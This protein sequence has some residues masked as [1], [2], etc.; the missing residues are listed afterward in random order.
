MT[1]IRRPTISFFVGLL[2]AIAA[3]LKLA[4]LVGEPS[5]RMG[6][7]SLESVKVAEI[8]FEFFLA[9]WLWSGVSPSWSW[10]T[11]V[12]VFM[13]FSGVSFNQAW[14]G[15]STCGCFGKVDVNPWYTFYLDLFVLAALALA[16][17]T[18]FAISEL[19]SVGIPTTRKRLVLGASA[20]AI[21]FAFTGVFVDFYF[22]SFHAALAN[23]KGELVVVDPFISDLGVCN[24]RDRKEV[25]VRV[26]NHGEKPVRIV[27]QTPDCSS[28]IA[29]KLPMEIPAHE[30][31]G[32]RLVYVVNGDVGI[33]TNDVVLFLDTGSLETLTFRLTGAISPK[34]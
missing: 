14:S 25:S 5:R 28:R 7:F 33:F 10:V 11:S 1:V 6:L 24:D 23:F 30:S 13:S 34:R 12:L 18:N 3:I 22:G 31:V 19:L 27:G 8:N 2:L 32:L 21:V 29:T 15:E 17:P 20:L 16:R 26:F 4:G 9:L